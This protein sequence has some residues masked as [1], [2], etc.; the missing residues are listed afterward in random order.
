M[1]GVRTADPPSPAPARDEDGS[2]GEDSQARK[3][4]SDD[5][6]GE[7]TA[8]P[9]KKI[10]VYSDDDDES[11]DPSDEEMTEADKRFIVDDEGEE[12]EEDVPTSQTP[13]RDRRR[14]RK[15][16]KREI[17][18][19]ES[20]LDAEDLELVHEN[21]GGTKKFKRLRRKADD[22]DVAKI[23]SDDD[24][25]PGRETHQRDLYDEDNME[26]FIIDD[27]EGEGAEVDRIPNPRKVKQSMGANL[28]R[29]MGIS[30]EQW[31]EYNNLFDCE[32]DYGWALHGKP[33]F[34]HLEENDEDA[35]SLKDKTL[36]LTDIYEPSEIAE[37][38]L[39]DADEII[40]LNDL[41]E[42]FQLRGDMPIP[43]PGELEREAIWIAR[44]L[45]LEKHVSGDANE[46]HPVV[47]S[48]VKVL[49]YFR[50]EDQKGDR[51]HFEVPFILA[52]RR[53]YI[54]G[55]LDRNDLWRV[56]DLDF[57]F[58]AF[59]NKKKSVL[60]LYKDIARL[61]PAA[62][63]D[64]YV[65]ELLSR[66]CGPED[67]MDVSLYIQLQYGHEL[68]QAE[69]SRRQTFKRARRQTPYDIARQAGI[70]E[71]VK[72]FACDARQIGSNMNAGAEKGLSPALTPLEAAAN[73]VNGPFNTA[74]KA[75][76]AARMML[77]QDM[78][79]DPMF[80][81]FVRKVYSSDATLTVSPTKKGKI[82]IDHRHPYYPFKYLSNKYLWEFTDGQFLQIHKAE[83]EGL[84][85][86]E[87]RI[88]AEQEFFDDIVK[89]GSFASGSDS[90]VAW[91]AEIR[92]ILDRACRESLFPQIVK[93]QKERLAASA[94]DFVALRCQMA[95][96]E[97]ITVAPLVVQDPEYED[98]WDPRVLAI[99]WGEGDSNAATWSLVVNETGEVLQTLKLDRFRGPA[100]HRGPD[101]DALIDMINT[102]NPKIVAIAGFKPNTKTI[103][104]RAVQ[105]ILQEALLSGRLSED[106][107]VIFVDD[108][109]ARVYMTSEVAL[110]DY[111]EK[112]YPQLVRYLVSL[113]RRVQDPLAEFAGLFEKDIMSLKLHPLQ[114]LI[115]EDKYN[116]ATEKAFVNVVNDVGVDINLAAQHAHRAVVLRFVSGLGPRKAQA[117]LNKISRSSGAGRLDARANLIRNKI[118]GKRIFMNC[119][120]FI[121]V[122]ERHFHV[123]TLDVLDD[124]RIH[125][126]DYDLARKMAADAL[127]YEDA[128][129]DGEADQSVHVS[130]LMKSPKD[131]QKLAHLA[132]D[133]F[134]ME[135]E[136]RMKE[137]KKMVLQDIMKE[138]MLPFGDRRRPFEP[139]GPAE[140]FTML[141]GETDDTLP[142]NSVVAVQI[143]R[144]T[145]RLLKCRLNSGLDGLIHIRQ[146]PIPPQQREPP[147]TLVGLFRE[148]SLLQARVI[149]VDKERLTVELSLL[150]V[151]ADAG[152]EAVP[153]DA[154][155]D[156]RREGDELAAQRNIDV[157]KAKTKQVRQIN[158]PYFKL[159]DYKAA[160]QYLENK[161]AGSVVI[162]PSTKGNDHFSITWKVEGPI[163][164]HVDVIE[165]NKENEMALGRVLTIDGERY[166]EIDQIIA[167]LIEPTNRRVQNT[168]THPK[169]Q[170]RSLDDMNRFIE[171]QCA[172]TRRSSYGLILARDKPCHLQLVYKH[173]QARGPPHHEHV[174]V[175]H[176]G[177]VFRKRMFGSVDEVLRFFKEDEA[178]RA[179]EAAKG[180]RGGGDAHRNGGGYP[181]QSGG[182]QP[183]RS[184]APAP[185]Q[186]MHGRV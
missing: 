161:P 73:F 88:S 32:M 75:L 116:W 92:K 133:E 167:E 148:D 168:L 33:D 34:M 138:I 130:D 81:A 162:R 53:D 97:K 35:P 93:W 71:L 101:V 163:C 145:D 151:S 108:D 186:Y 172:S 177:Y 185:G 154:R 157:R 146:V 76:E 129:V 87:V 26:D 176:K 107:Q 29:S 170:R 156:R 54:D 100:E 12:D 94:R 83:Q 31:H 58:V 175:R 149:R 6:S 112:H 37:K 137:K 90:D 21:S 89:R 2:E 152:R 158:H 42:R 134:A 20:D 17:S 127:D 44:Q 126:E 113:A 28:G 56:Y 14:K 3:V 141:S 57:Q 99:S 48:I 11:D 61:S 9:S 50:G 91:N 169:Y 180:Q 78:A 178:K 160:M 67:I 159:M 25:A 18:E 121:R 124:T 117:F 179:A 102:H 153:V 105:D 166:S 109:V 114:Y 10:G 70:P 77:A 41:P 40:R 46:S 150:N 140:I 143:T 39:T 110:R 98:E 118:T 119:S 38:L 115:A 47:Q 120:S 59:E 144:V 45:F 79:V 123:G 139:A 49:T 182:P 16:R 72:M 63:Q 69:Q 84:I 136:R 68:A 104:H 131:L 55:L 135:L 125:P 184:A 66:A 22:D 62:A 60:S 132:L 1:E 181:Q 30:D 64:A 103:L 13:S 155:F 23:F 142:E 106:L 27:D 147:Q 65:E 74:E 86:T 80:R 8:R 5:E 19:S 4:A 111:P 174:Q 51:P 96:E 43:E 183:Y 164:Q 173:P 15:R 82:E 85:E 171:E 122:R 52:H 36:K 7:D 165:S 24:E 95:L 128:V